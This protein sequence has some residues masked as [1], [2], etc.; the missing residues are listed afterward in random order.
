MA[1]L[2][3]VPMVGALTEAMFFKD[4]LM[5][6]LPKD[7][8][9]IEAKKRARTISMDIEVQ[10]ADVVVPSKVIDELIDRSR[11]VFKLNRCPC[12][13]ANG[14]KDY[15]IE[16]GCIFLGRGA[17]KIPKHLG[18]MLTAE[19]AKAHMKRCREAGLVHLIGR[20]KIDSVV[21]SQGPKE[22]LLS[23]CSCCPCCCLWKM[24]PDLNQRIASSLEKMPGIEIVAHPD[25]CRGCSR[26]VKDSICYV[27][28]LSIVDGKVQ[29]DEGLCKGCGRCVE[30]C[31][32]RAIELRILD[33]SYIQ[34]SIGRIE[35][36]VDIYRA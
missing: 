36:L 4:D 29:I 30:F 35:P 24:V 3:R 27:N 14:C 33:D 18:K 32:D 17:D 11:Y 5:F 13:D 16:Y 6:V 15:P 2:T 22:E 12:R 1:R 8:V 28:A 19:E 21:F 34:G 26:C 7:D 23:I 20:N 10:K 25:L 31:K 9:F